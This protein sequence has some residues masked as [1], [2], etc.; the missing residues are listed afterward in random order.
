MGQMYRRGFIVGGAAAGSPLAPSAVPKTQ[1]WTFAGTV[2]SL[3]G[4]WQ[5]A[6]DPANAGR[7]ERWYTRDFPGA[8]S[9]RVPSIIQEYFPGYHGVAWYGREFDCPRNQCPRGRYLL[10]FHAVDYLADVW[11]NGVHAGSHEGGE[12]PF[13]LDVTGSIR[14]GEAN[15]LAVR[16]LNPGHERIDGIVLNE[17][18]H[19]NKAIP[20]VPGS[21]FNTGGITE[22]VELMLAPA[23][24]LTD[25]F[26]RADP[27]SGAVELRAAV[28]NAGAKPARVRVEFGIAAGAGGELA[29]YAQ[30]DSEAAP[31]DSAVEGKLVVRNPELWDLKTPA[32]YRAT[33][34]LMN[35]GALGE[36][37]T[38]FG[39]R[40]FRV[41]DG[42]FR[43]NGNRL[44]LR[45]THTGNHSP[46][47]QI[48][49]PAQALDVLRLDMLYAKSSGYNMVRFISGIA[50][51]YQLDLCDE[52]GLMVYEEC[53]A[54]WLL[55]ESPKMAE[56]FDRS[57]AEM[58]RRDR[59]HPSVTIWG[60]LNETR[61]G[62]VFRK[63]VAALPMVRGLDD[64]RL[65][66][67]ASGR[68]DCD[69]SIGSVSNPGSRQ[70]EHQW[71]TEA[72]GAPRTPSDWNKQAGGY[73]QGAG[74]AHVYPGVPQT[75]ETNDFIRTLGRGSKPVFLSEYGIG[76][77]FDAIHEA[78]RF[79]QAG[80]RPDLEDYALISSMAERFTA[81]WGRFRM[82]GVYAFPEDMLRD[83][84]RLMARQ[85]V[86]GFDLVRSNPRICGFN[87][88]GMLDHA[89]TGEGLWRFWRDWKPGAMDALQD[90]W[91][92]L[93]WCLF[94]NPPHAYSGKV[95]KLEAVLAND[96]V[97]PPGE[98][99]ALFRVLG[100]GGIAWEGQA[101]VRVPEDNPLAVPVFATEARISGPA[102]VYEFVANLERG[103]A[104]LGRTVRFY[105]S[106]PPL[107]Q[108]T[109]SVETWGLNPSVERWLGA[110]G[111]P[112]RPFKGDSRGVV[113]VGTP[114][115]GDADSWER[116]MDSVSRGSVAVFLSP[117]AFRRGKDPAARLPLKNKGR[118][119]EFND[120]LYH[121]ECVAGRHPMFE[122]L[123]PPGI[124]DWDY[125]GPIIT[126]TL[127]DCRD[128]PDDV[129]AAAF[130][131]GYSIPGGYASGILAG[132]Y[133]H[134]EG[135]FVLNAFRVLENIDAHPAADRMLLNLIRYAAGFVK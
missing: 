14:P 34:R 31:G 70:W 127:F 65:V 22:P 42:Y 36:R 107:P 113:L 28:C 124:M 27:K 96:G 26:V 9:V 4:G 32:L 118:V 5:L 52:I 30:L 76:S 57:V 49:A 102:G 134:G 112:S 63:A 98:Y 12:T 85:R 67:L 75:P 106:D 61:D 23:V 125:Y 18:P 29:S 130:A 101:Q 64:T 40:D 46:I 132:S 120:W 108:G 25:L 7:R 73:F 122:G 126:R 71:G 16:V 77:L 103:G 1:P 110:H 66:L 24:R 80:A 90:G 45:S 43:L 95:V 47:G 116:L 41:V 54:G 91:A 109:H 39:F 55:G 51:P 68:W 83:S 89:L 33:A 115:E 56:R 88:T 79:E 3:D 2:L 62:V 104:P 78:R 121:K 53:Y 69:P 6:I 119:Y 111:S 123:A 37:S 48:I 105:L 86:L 87:V 58:I 72:P 74:D 59:N 19:R 10:R 13:V 8:Q 17:T 92:P 97:L 81:D 99:P 60:M 21:S 38:R 15:R 100:P 117:A 114:P 131:V 82:D 94:A 133:R 11:V 35:N 129:A 128:T 84:Q 44:F 135:R 50:H 20:Y 93:R